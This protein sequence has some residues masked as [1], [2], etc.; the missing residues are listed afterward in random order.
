MK[1]DTLKKLAYNQV[2]GQV[3]ITNDTLKITTETQR[4]V[5]QYQYFTNLNLTFGVG[6]TW[7]KNSFRYQ[8][9]ADF[10]LSLLQKQKANY[11]DNNLSLQPL[12]AVRKIQSN[13]QIHV[14]A[15]YQYNMSTSIFGRMTY[16]Q[17]L[18]SLDGIANYNALLLNFGVSKKI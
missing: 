11:L 17:S 3:Y 18:S 8:V 4:K 5:L 7:N 1:P 9:G 2:T 12:A 15:A 10:G 13:V 14:Q 6:K 16:F